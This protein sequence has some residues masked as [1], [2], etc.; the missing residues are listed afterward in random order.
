MSQKVS[1]VDK[2]NDNGD[3]NNEAKKNND[4]YHKG[5][6]QKREIKRRKQFCEMLWYWCFYAQVIQGSPYLRTFYIVLAKSH[7]DLVDSSLS[8]LAWLLAV[9]K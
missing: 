8:G 5:D 4:K 2:D 1:D 3:D 9:I 7:T 6:N